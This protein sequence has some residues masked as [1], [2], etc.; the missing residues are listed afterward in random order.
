MIGIVRVLVVFALGVGGSSLGGAVHVG[1]WPIGAYLIGVR[2]WSF[3]SCWT[4]SP[5]RSVRVV[6]IDCP[7]RQWLLSHVLWFFC[8]L[9][10]LAGCPVNLNNVEAAFARDVEVQAAIDLFRQC[11]EA[12]L[13]E[14]LLD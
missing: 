11:L 8:S 2:L 5:L 13:T 9:A 3:I 10:V 1:Q 6:C 14:L 7:A 12:A 4:V